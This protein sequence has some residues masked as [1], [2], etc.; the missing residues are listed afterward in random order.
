MVGLP[1]FYFY[2]S[3]LFF[4]IL[5]VSAYIVG[6]IYE[7]YQLLIATS[8]CKIF[9]NILQHFWSNTFCYS[10]WILSSL[11][12]QWHCQ[13]HVWPLCWHELNA[14]LC[15]FGLTMISISLFTNTLLYLSVTCLIVKLKFEL[16]GKH[17]NI[18]F[19]SQNI[20][21]IIHK[22]FSSLMTK[23]KFYLLFNFTEK[24]YW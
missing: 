21:Q 4:F 2:F 23:V 9:I 16:F 22:Q 19:F 8:I 14:K 12:C 18:N 6:R 15:W 10:I 5:K 11:L 7:D 17:K 13:K 24:Y 3:Y 20:A 1:C